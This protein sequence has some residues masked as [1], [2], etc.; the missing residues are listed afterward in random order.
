[1]NIIFTPLAKFKATDKSHKGALILPLA[2]EKKLPDWAAAVDKATGGAIAR[3]MASSRFEGKRKQVMTLLAPHGVNFDVI[4][5]VGL[6]KAKDICPRTFEMA[7]GAIIAGLN[8]M[9]VKE[10]TARVQAPKDVKVSDSE[11]AVHFALGAQ[12]KSYR[13]DKYKTKEKAESKPTLTTIRIAAADKAKAAYEDQKHVVESVLFARDLINEPGNVIYPETLAAACQSLSKLGLDVEVMGEAKLKKLGCGALLGVGQGSVR[14]SQM[15]VM[16][17]NGADKKTAPVAFI[18][19]GVTFDTGG[20]SIKPANGME[21]MIMDMG[22]AAAVI[23]LMRAL[24]AGKAKVNAVGVVGL[25]ENMPDGN[26]QRPGDIV[27]SMSGQT[28]EVLN[29][30]AEGRLV[31]ADCLWYTQDRFKP[32][33]MINLATLTGAILVAIGDTRAGLFSNNDKLAERLSEVGEKSGEPVWRLPLGEEY[34]RLIDSPVADMKNIS[35]GRLAGSV[36]AAQFLQRFV[37]DYP[38]AHLDIAGTAWSSK[39]T[40][41]S[42]RGA[43]GYGIRLLHSLVMKYYVK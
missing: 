12:L 22:G 11:A 1:M 5:L 15:V 42:P 38:W 8:S 21:E 31:L 18:G 34:D 35:D 2:E 29:T 23:G 3:A 41:L 40:D 4:M 30:D 33:F 26:A 32:Q 6:G 19:K 7:G 24:A 25:V 37:N 20:I 9:G 14:E 27:T 10:A 43:T 28:I 13:F 39:G 16:R 36:T 17:W